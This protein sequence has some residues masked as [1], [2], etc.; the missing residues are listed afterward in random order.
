MRLGIWFS[1]IY[2]WVTAFATHEQDLTPN[3]I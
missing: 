3:L 1:K 2:I